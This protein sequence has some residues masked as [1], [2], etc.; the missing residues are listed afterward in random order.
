MAQ[1]DSR[2]DTSGKGQAFF[3]RAEQVAETG[4]WD[5]AIEMFLQGIQREP[6][7]IEQGHQRLREVSMA[8]TVQGGKGPGFGEKLKHK[9]G[10]TPE[11][12]LANAEFLLAK[13]PGS[14]QYMMQVIAAARKLEIPELIGWIANILFDSQRK[15]KKAS[16]RVLQLLM[17]AFSEAKHYASAVSA[18]ETALTQAPTDSDLQNRLKEY[19]TKDTIQ[20]GKYDEEGS[21]VKGVKNMDKQ[22]ELIQKD[23]MVQGREFLEGEV[24]RTLKEYEQEPTVPGKINA[25]VEALC[26]LEEEAYENQAVDILAKAYKDT[27]AYQFKMRIGDVRI[28]Q[29][30]R[31]RR[32]LLAEGDREG[33]L[34]EARKQLEFELAEYAERAGNYPTDLSIKYELGRRQLASADIDGAIGS[35]QQASRDPRRQAQAMDLLGQAYVKKGW[36]REAAD[37]YERALQDDL[38]ERRAKQIHYNFGDALERMGELAQAQE[39][40]SQV[41]QIDYNFKDARTRLDAVRKKLESQTGGDGAKDQS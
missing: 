34:R 2:N 16:L 40:F 7:N 35:L 3:E 36:Y 33:A 15:A 18:C 41:A 21:F 29:M 6:G 9:G 28:R 30:T 22:K 32:T 5:F 11:E 31:R 20:K 14:E 39:Q 23:A 8:R 17:D 1:P 19:S 38:P 24:E 25:A 37:T 26:K 4:N 12:V 27:E 13:E 10:K